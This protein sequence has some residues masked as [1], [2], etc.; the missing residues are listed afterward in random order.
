[1]EEEV[2]ADWRLEFIKEARS[3]VL[4]VKAYGKVFEML[5]QKLSNSAISDCDFN[6]TIVNVINDEKMR[7]TKRGT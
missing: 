5:E 1:V 3:H 4:F 7:R 2:K 6:Q